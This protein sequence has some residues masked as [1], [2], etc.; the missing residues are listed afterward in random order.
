M[1]CVHEHVN[2]MRGDNPVNQDATVV[3]DMLNGVHG[4]ARPRADIDIFV[5]QIMPSL[6]ERRPMQETMSP[7]KVEQPP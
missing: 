7:I 6:V 3:K 2:G 5:M 1:L 4:Q